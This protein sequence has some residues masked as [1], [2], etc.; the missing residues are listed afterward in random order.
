M[1]QCI[2]KKRSCRKRNKGDC[3]NVYKYR[4]SVRVESTRSEPFDVKVGVDQGLVLSPFLFA[5]VMDEVTEDVREG[6]AK[7][8]LRR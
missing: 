6:V 3:G 4:T 5:I 1:N 7:K 2:K 8:L